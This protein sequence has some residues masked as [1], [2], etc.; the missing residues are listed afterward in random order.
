MIN[1]H[2]ACGKAFLTKPE[3]AGKKTRC[4]NCGNSLSIPGGAPTE[5]EL[6]AMLG[7]LP[8]PPATPPEPAAAWPPGVPPLHSSKDRKDGARTDAPFKPP[9]IEKARPSQRDYAAVDLVALRGIFDVTF[10][11]LVTPAVISV[12]YRIY[13]V[14]AALSVIAL[15]GLNSFALIGIDNRRSR[16]ADSLHQYFALAVSD[17]AFLLVL[18]V[19]TLL[20]RLSCEFVMVIFRAESQLQQLVELQSD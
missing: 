5:Q 2:C 13:L 17:L 19:M 4:P 6:A 16:G 15:I 9:V 11:N 20:V 18:F 8:P 10:Q 3:N 1:V 7:A 12:L 14:L